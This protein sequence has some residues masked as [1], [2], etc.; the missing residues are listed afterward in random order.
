MNKHQLMTPLRNEINK[1]DQ[2]D[3]SKL[4]PDAEAWLKDISL[5][6]ELAANAGSFAGTLQE[7]AKNLLDGLDFLSQIRMLIEKLSYYAFLLFSGDTGAPENQERQSLMDQ[8]E[9]RAQAALSFFEPELLKISKKT[10][11]AYT[12]ELPELD[13]YQIMIDKLHRMQPHILPVNEEQLLA[14]YE[15]S[16]N[17]AGNAFSLLMNADIDF[18][19]VDTAK[20]NKPLSRQ[21]L[22]WFLIQP[23]RDLR[24]R[25]YNQYYETFKKHEHTLAALYAGSIHNDV[26]VSRIRNYPSARA[27]ILFKDAIQESVYDNMV[28]TVHEGLPLFHEFIRLKKNLLGLN[29]L[30]PYDLELPLIQSVSTDYP[31]EK[32]VETVIAAL[33]PFGRE[34]TNTLR[35]GLL[36][37][38]VDR[39]ENKRKRSGAFTAAC[40]AGEPFI[41]LN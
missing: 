18:G 26:Y 27:S 19:I 6:E 31:Y 33:E 21:N 4:Y 20:G 40:Y 17:T 29:A 15:E 10:L 5:I 22:S 34:Y 41:L 8:V 36:Y 2:W 37:G 3:L 30:R 23:D 7:S 35:Q 13:N 39:Y 38:W 32:A 16:S 25:A 24:R 14:L 12:A 9:A 1:S 11:S 28:K